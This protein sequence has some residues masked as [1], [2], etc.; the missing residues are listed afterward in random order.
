MMQVQ[1]EYYETYN[2]RII[3]LNPELKSASIKKIMS[4]FK[5]LVKGLRMKITFILSYYDLR[6]FF[7]NFVYLYFF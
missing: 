4:Y 5:E 2:R 7:M 1:N 3:I 6:Y